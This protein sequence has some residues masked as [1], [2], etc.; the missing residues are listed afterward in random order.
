MKKPG[1]L[2]PFI[3]IITAL[4]LLVSGCGPVTVTPEPSGKKK[5]PTLKP[6]TINGK[7]YY[8]IETADGFWETGTASWYGKKFH[9]RKTANGE[10]YNMYAKTAAHKTLPMDTVLLV[11]NLDNGRETVVRVNDRGPFVRGRI[12]DLSYK[13]AS[14]IGLVKSGLARAKIIAMGRPAGTSG[15]AGKKPEKLEHQNFYKGNYFVQVGSFLNKNNA[16]RLARVFISQGIK[17][18]IQPYIT[19]GHTYFRVQ[20]FA[21]TSLKVAKILEQKLLNTGF[22]GSFI[23]AR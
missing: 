5:A 11:Q 10:T 14:E 18:V 13:A 19:S 6:Y 1:S 12:I 17:V 20:V 7:T 23:F 4:L 2:F 16:E 8:P 22:P 3:L 15:K 9:G 21:G